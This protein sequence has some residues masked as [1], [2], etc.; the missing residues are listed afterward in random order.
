MVVTN[1]TA[2]PTEE[3][4]TVQEINLSWPILHAASFYVGKYCEPYNNEFLLCQ[5]EEKDATKCVNE[6]K[7]VTGCALE[8]FRKLKKHCR[9][10]FD[11]YYNCLYKS[12][13]DLSFNHCRNT[14]E[15]LDKCVLEHMN[16]ERPPFGYFCEV[17][18][19]ETTRPKPV[20]KI[21][22]YPTVPSLPPDAPKPPAR[23]EGRWMV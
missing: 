5:K 9:Q 7:A 18:V 22:E 13:Y 23:F 2:I 21:P 4:L 12:S 1:K 6:G 16:V 10:E 20:E 3:E 11:Q 8:F 17:K 19:H 14:Q 15:V